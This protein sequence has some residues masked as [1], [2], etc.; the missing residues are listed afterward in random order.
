MPKLQ[1]PVILNDDVQIVTRTDDG[2]YI[3]RFTNSN[4]NI[5][6]IWLP[7]TLN[8]NG[9]VDSKGSAAIEMVK[10]YINKFPVLN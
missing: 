10:E 4:G 6:V 1:F 5:S 9:V 2:F 7:D 3:I 8:I